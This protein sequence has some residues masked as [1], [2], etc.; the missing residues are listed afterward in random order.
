MI[1][2]TE[3]EEIRIIAHWLRHL[4]HTDSRIWNLTDLIDKLAREIRGHF[5]L[6][7]AQWAMENDE[8]LTEPREAFGF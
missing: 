7:K 5:A 2:Q 3:L 8:K 1:H 6:N 4:E